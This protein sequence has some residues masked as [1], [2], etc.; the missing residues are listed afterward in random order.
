M[1]QYQQ[2]R[3]LQEIDQ[4]LRAQLETLETELALLQDQANML[5]TDDLSTDNQ[6]VR[7]LL[8]ASH[9]GNGQAAAAPAPASRARPPASSYPPYPLY[10]SY[11][12][13]VS[14]P[15]FTQNRLPDLENG[16]T[17]PEQSPARRPL[18]PLPHSEA[19]LLPDDVA[20]FFDS[21]GSTEPQLELPWWLHSL[22]RGN[23]RA[24]GNDSPIPLDPES[25]RTNRLVQRWFE[26]WGRSTTQPQP[27]PPTREQKQE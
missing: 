9:N 23:K 13:N 20:A 27:Q 2:W 17:D 22:T 6:F 15:F 16:L 14:S 25:V 3:Q 1:G 12:P 7:L 24:N 4:R 8:T 21:H 10:S 18:P 5:G 11:P 19:P 26:R